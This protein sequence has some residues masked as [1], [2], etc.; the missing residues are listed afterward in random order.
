[1][2][3]VPLSLP[4]QLLLVW[5]GFSAAFIRGFGGSCKLI[6]RDVMFLQR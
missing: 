1:V 6:S 2:C 4:L 3:D 5:G